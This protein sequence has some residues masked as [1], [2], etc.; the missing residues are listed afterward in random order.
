MFFILSTT[1]LFSTGQA[2]LANGACIRFMRIPFTHIQF[3]TPYSMP[4]IF[5]VS[6][7]AS[8]LVI[9]ALGGITLWRGTRHGIASRS[10]E[11]R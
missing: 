10:A 1:A 5:L 9:I 6:T 7:A 2:L 3:R 4:L 11:S 8:G